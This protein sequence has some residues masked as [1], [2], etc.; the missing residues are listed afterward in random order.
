METEGLSDMNIRTKPK[1]SG[2]FFFF[3]QEGA[4]RYDGNIILYYVSIIPARSGS[5]PIFISDR[6]SVSIEIYFFPG[7]EKFPFWKWYDAY[8]IVIDPLHKPNGNTSGTITG[9]DFQFEWK[10]KI[11]IINEMFS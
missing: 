10:Q 9:Y 3:Y 1:P 6:S 7:V 11:T 5:V 4:I 2:I 8:R